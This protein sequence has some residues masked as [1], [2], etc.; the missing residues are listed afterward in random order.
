VF[1]ASAGGEY[2]IGEVGSTI[3]VDDFTLT[4]EQK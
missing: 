4:F 3:F 2:F 1:A